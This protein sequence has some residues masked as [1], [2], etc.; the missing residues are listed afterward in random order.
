MTQEK[1][2]ATSVSYLKM[3]SH[4]LLFVV[5]NKAHFNPVYAKNGNKSGSRQ[6]FYDW[7]RPTGSN[8]LPEPGPFNK[9]VFFNP[10]LALSGPIQ[11]LLGLIYGPIRP[12]L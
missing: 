7:T 9:R 11:P 4:Y 2:L 1:A 6:F 10:K 3:T 8:L 5:V 12:N